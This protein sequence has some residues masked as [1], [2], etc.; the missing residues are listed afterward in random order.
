LVKKKI[1]KIKKLTFV[2]SQTIT[3]LSADDITLSGVTSVTKGT[4]TT[5]TPVG[6]YPTWTKQE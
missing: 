1:M 6:S 5:T 4:Y 3:G 2:F